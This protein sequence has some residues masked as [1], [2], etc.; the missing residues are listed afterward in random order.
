MQECKAVL[1]YCQ[2]LYCPGR[3]LE[4]GLLTNK[5]QNVQN[6]PVDILNHL[7]LLYKEGGSGGN[8]S[9]N[10]LCRF[11]ARTDNRIEPIPCGERQ[12]FEDD[13]GAI[14]TQVLK[15]PLVIEKE[16]INFD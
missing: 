10:L 3:C 9:Y 15:R 11:A 7:H 5:Y 6:V 1:R 16:R 14:H 8:G 12:W 13:A 4:C 2:V